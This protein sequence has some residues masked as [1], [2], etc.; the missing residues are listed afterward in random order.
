[1]NPV[2]ESIRWLT[3]MG[4]AEKEAQ[5]IAGALRGKTQEAMWEAAPL[6]LEWAGEMKRSHECI[7]QLAAMGLLTVELERKETGDGWQTYLSL[8]TGDDKRAG[9]DVMRMIEADPGDYASKAIL[10]APVFVERLLADNRRLRETARRLVDVMERSD[11]EQ[12][13]NA[14][15]VSGEEW[16][17]AIREAKGMLA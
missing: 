10:F 15:P 12:F 16:F 5:H 6:W 2:K 14:Q 4:W 1:M 11:L 13:E 17:D 3:E 9:I 7:L 8:N